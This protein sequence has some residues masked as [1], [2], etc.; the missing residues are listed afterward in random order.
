MPTT[1]APY[2]PEFR[3]EALRLVRTSKRPRALIARELG[4]TAETLRLSLKQAKLDDGRR[5]DGPTIEERT[6]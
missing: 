6:E 4:L 3:A 5:D 2:P 1:R